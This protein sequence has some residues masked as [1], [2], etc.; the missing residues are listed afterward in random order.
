[1]DYLINGKIVGNWIAALQYAL[2]S[3][4]K[5]CNAANET[6]DDLIIIGNAPKYIK[7]DAIFNMQELEEDLPYEDKFIE[8]A[9]E[10]CAESPLLMKRLDVHEATE[11]RLSMH[12]P[13]AIA[14]FLS[15]YLKTEDGIKNVRKEYE[16]IIKAYGT[17]QEK[18]EKMIK[19]KDGSDHLEVN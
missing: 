14:D 5:V 7:F 12:N 18:I 2:L 10:L 15:K 6:D 13:I 19:K 1:M 4:E 16:D 17:A 11:S 8:K 3:A 9:R